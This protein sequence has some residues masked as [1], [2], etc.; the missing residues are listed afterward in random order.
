[1]SRPEPSIST[2]APDNRL[3]S[4]LWR[5]LV[6]RRVPLSTFTLLIAAVCLIV[7]LAIGIT[8]GITHGDMLRWLGTS[9]GVM[10]AGVLVGLAIVIA[11]DKL[12]SRFVFTSH[13]VLR[14]AFATYLIYLVGGASGAVFALYVR[15]IL[16]E[17]YSELELTQHVL[18]ALITAF[19][20]GV[21]GLV[22]N[23]MRERMEKRNEYQA[24]LRERIIEL[25]AS[26]RRIVI[27][28]ETLR[29]QIAGRLHGPVQTSLLILQRRLGECQ[30]RI[31]SQ[32]DKATDLLA[33]IAQEL[34]KIRNEDL[35]SI[36]KE[37]HPSIIKMGLCA[38]LRSLR[39][40][41]SSLITVKLDI[42]EVALM[43]DPANHLITEETG[44]AL[45]RL[46]EEALN[47]TI[48]HAQATR[49]V[50]RLWQPDTEHVELS[51]E[52]NG[53]GF[54]VDTATPGLGMLAMQDYIGAVGGSFDI[55]SSPQKGT[56]VKA[57]VPVRAED[58]GLSANSSD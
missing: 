13:S 4:W 34:D 40:N 33:Q 10:A 9:L 21:I 12:R 28:Q 7:A 45:Y 16:P 52:D 57:R 24:A 39:D 6:P 5:F 19:G 27:A 14:A 48:K 36:G 22:S 44:L 41:F 47:N 35:R 56:V 54:D 50:L 31:R 25:E 32:P 42:E 58:T 43:D 17:G 37:L 38:G 29:R 46:T 20:W 18:A 15:A 8:L 1:M 53:V 3:T 23:H 30:E 11:L 49:V 51:V 2:S 26:R 55:A